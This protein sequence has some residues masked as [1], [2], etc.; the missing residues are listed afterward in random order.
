MDFIQWLKSH[1][2][3]IGSRTY[4]NIIVADNSDYDFVLHYN[5]YETFKKLLKSENETSPETCG[6][7]EYPDLDEQTFGEGFQC[8]TKVTL[9]S[10]QIVNCF[11]FD[12]EDTLGKYEIL[13]Q[14]MLQLTPS[15]VRLKSRRVAHFAHIQYVL[16]ISGELDIDL[17]M[18]LFGAYRMYFKSIGAIK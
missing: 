9:K 14:T 10:G 7:T 11:V 15:D 8:N 2:L 17:N 4:K 18:E 13:Q 6:G 16:D 5:S 12:D 1:G 3:A